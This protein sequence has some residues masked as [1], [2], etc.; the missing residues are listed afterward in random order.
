MKEN[1][2]NCHK[3]KH[4]DGPMMSRTNCHPKLNKIR[5]PYGMQYEEFETDI[6]NHNGD[7]KDFKRAKF[8]GIF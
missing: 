3:C 5:T 1:C 7:C 2:A 4:W 8:L 6:K